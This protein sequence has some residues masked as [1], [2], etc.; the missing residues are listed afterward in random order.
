V[1]Q[2]QERSIAAAPRCGTVSSGEG[3]DAFGGGPLPQR[4]LARP[5]RRLLGEVATADGCPVAAFPFVQ[6][7]PGST[8]SAIWR[9]VYS[10]PM[11]NGVL[12]RL[13]SIEWDEQA[14]ARREQ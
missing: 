14:Q 3:G 9:R 1:G 10:P 12:I 13:C 2:R 11:T 8:R 4:A 5:P 6:S 7:F